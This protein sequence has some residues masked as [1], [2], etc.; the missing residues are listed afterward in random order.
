VP[1]EPEGRRFDA[2]EVRLE[3]DRN[4]EMKDDAEWLEF[5]Q[6][7]LKPMIYC[8]SFFLVYRDAACFQQPV[9]LGILQAEK[10]ESVI[11]GVGVVQLPLVR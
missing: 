6:T 11:L 2:L 5:K 8:E 3:Q 4:L 9:D 10:V 7:G 1:P